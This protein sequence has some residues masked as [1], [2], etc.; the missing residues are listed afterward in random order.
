MDQCGNFKKLNGTH[1][2][3][4]VNALIKEYGSKICLVSKSSSKTFKKYQKYKITNA[5]KYVQKSICLPSG[6]NLKN[7]IYKICQILNAK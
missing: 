3:K 4:L 7:D 5:L 1:H 2:N 6:L